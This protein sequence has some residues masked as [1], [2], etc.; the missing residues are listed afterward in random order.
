LSP[1]GRA[2]F[3]FGASS[4]QAELRNYGDPAIPFIGHGPAERLRRT[5]WITTRATRIRDSDRRRSKA[6]EAEKTGASPQRQPHLVMAGLV[7]AIHAVPLRSFFRNDASGSA[8]IPGTR[9]GMTTL[10]CKSLANDNRYISPDSR[11]LQITKLR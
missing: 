1:P 2:N 10:G 9:P 4:L 3:L 6:N 7:P 8:W 5:F 11:A